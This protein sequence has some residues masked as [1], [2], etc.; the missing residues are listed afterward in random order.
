MIWYLRCNYHFFMWRFSLLCVWIYLICC[1]IDYFLYSLM[2]VIFLERNTY[3]YLTFT[4]IRT[5]A[6]LYFRLTYSLRSF[7]MVKVLKR[8][9]IGGG[10]GILKDFREFLSE[11]LL[12]MLS[13][14][15]FYLSM[16]FCAT[17]NGK[18]VLS[19]FQMRMNVLPL[20]FYSKWMKLLKI[21]T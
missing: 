19:L 14:L 12:W 20:I 17:P 18:F 15:F 8:A 7:L 1:S 4:F 5:L 11:L 6:F 2:I 3:L 16:K 13:S 9:G 21:T 10:F